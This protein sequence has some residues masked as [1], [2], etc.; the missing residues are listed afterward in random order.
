MRLFDRRTAQER[1]R[2]NENK[3]RARIERRKARHKEE[4]KI[5][6]KKGRQDA[7]RASKGIGGRVEGL[8]GGFTRGVEAIN[9]GSDSLAEGMFGPNSFGL[10]QPARRKKKS[11]GKPKRKEVYYY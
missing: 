3:T 10:D 11:K 4:I 2:D 1:F 9:R 7:R 5:A 6:R 8:L